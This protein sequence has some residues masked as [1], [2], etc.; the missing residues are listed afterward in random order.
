[1]IQDSF[2]HLEAIRVG[3]ECTV[4]RDFRSVEL[5]DHLLALGCQGDR[6]EFEGPF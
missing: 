2:L 6:A 4:V 3:K 5:D 1:M